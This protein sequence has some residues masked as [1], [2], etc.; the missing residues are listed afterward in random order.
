MSANS[1]ATKINGTQV[2]G[3]TGTN[4]AVLDTSP[5]IV[6]PTIS[7]LANLTTNGFVKTSASDG[8]L[9][10]DTS[11]YL[12]SV[13]TGNPNEITY[14]SGA[15]T[16]G[17]LAV[18]TYPNLTELSYVKGVT[19]AIQTQINAKGVGDM[20]LGTIQTVTAAKTFN[21]GKLLLNNVA[22]T[23]TG[24][25]TNTNT[26][27]RTYTLKDASGTLAF[28]TDITGTNSGTN[29]GDQTITLTGHVTG[30]G[31][32]SFATSTAS[33]MILQGTADATTTAAQFL[34]AL[35]TGLVKNTTTTGVLSIGVAATDYVA[36]SAYASANGLTMATARLLGRTTASSGAAEEITVGSGLTLSAGTLSASG[37]SATATTQSV[38]QTTHGF[39]VNDVIKFSGTTYQ[40]AKADTAANAEVVGIVTAVAD[41]NNFTFAMEGYVTGLSA[42]TSDTVYFLSDATAGLLT[43]AEPTATN[44]I[45]KPILKTTSTT[46]GIIMNMRG[47]V[48]VPSRVATTI[49]QA[50]APAINTDTVS[51]AHITG[52]AQAITSMTTNL[53]GTPTEGQTLRIDIT[54]NG[55]A[56]AITWG[57][58]FESSTVTLPTTT[59]LST[60][61]DIGFVWNSVTSKWRCVATA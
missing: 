29:T 59:V 61:L 56:R 16:L 30:S 5:T 50:A 43:A 10:I 34:G 18:A 11:T 49:T 60:R 35:S 58:S 31:T 7:K 57:T 51:I 42:L 23:F 28:T 46:T 22:G 1:N 37:G 33:K 2:T 9:G 3:T 14:W 53:T 40:K 24:Q 36:P 55:T 26:A 4:K 47:S 12:T 39:A 19:S 41:A 45:S 8:T 48:I 21:D 20:L 38:T 52:L 15:N 25:F 32:G 27:A 44:S 6:T 17:T 13:G 54:D